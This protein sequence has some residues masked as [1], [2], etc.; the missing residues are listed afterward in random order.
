MS[1]QELLKNGLHSKSKD[2]YLLQVKLWHDPFHFLGGGPNPLS[3][4]L[5]DSGQTPESNTPTVMSLSILVLLT[6]WEKPMKS[7]DLVV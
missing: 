7:H 3:L 6:C 5:S 2:D 1:N 4:K